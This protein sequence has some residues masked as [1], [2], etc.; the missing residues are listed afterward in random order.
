[1]SHDDDPTI[2]Q[3]VERLEATI[4]A[5]SSELASVRAQLHQ[6][7]PPSWNVPPVPGPWGPPPQQHGAMPAPPAGGAAAP[8]PSQRASMSTE[9][10]VSRLG[11]GLLIIGLGFLFK[12]GVDRGM[13][14]PLARVGLGAVLGVAMLAGGGALSASRAALSQVL[15]GGAMAALFT[16]AWAAHELYGLVPLAPTLVGLAA[17]HVLY[18]A[19][20]VR[21]SRVSLAVIGALGAYATPLMLL[22]PD[23]SDV[24]MQVWVVA[25]GIGVGA[26]IAARG[27]SSLVWLAGIPAWIATAAAV[28]GADESSGLAVTSALMT[29][30]VFGWLPALRPMLPL[31]AVDR[32]SAAA[33]VVPISALLAITMIG[34]HLSMSRAPLGWV[35]LGTAGAMAALSWL[36]NR[37][38]TDDPAASAMSGATALTAIGA[39]MA[40]LGYVLDEG[41]PRQAAWIGAA[42]ALSIVAGRTRHRELAQMALIAWLPPLLVLIG[43][44]GA[45]V[46]GHD[47]LPATTLLL[48]GALGVAMLCSAAL[49]HALAHRSA[50]AVVGYT[51][52]L[53]WAFFPVAQVDNGA[54]FGSVV[55]AVAG[56][57]ALV[58]GLRVGVGAARLIGMATLVGLV[59]KLLLI[60]L[61]ALAAVWRI[62]MFMGFGIAFLGLGYLVPRLTRDASE[63]AP[64]AD[65]DAG[66]T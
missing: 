53:G 30:L 25:V 64:D 60:D 24:A 13:L 5:L 2:E 50:V 10:L 23:G 49:G 8:S 19:L 32:A 54:V 48:D 40:G 14:G 51:S 15:M 34:E 35:A 27:W 16:T 3:R 43:H 62:L 29:W 7:P 20:S 4:E 26:V 9:A 63:P 33:P 6:A 22:A 57:G 31:P 12:Y 28:L 47:A 11:I 38:S 17:L 39:L 52:L 45:A 61:S 18:F 37:R 66:A 65:G 36:L 56:V 41:D 58:Y 44:V 42:A 46:D 21:L 55:W 59:A 1:M